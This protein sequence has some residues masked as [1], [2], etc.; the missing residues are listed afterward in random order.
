MRF[1]NLKNFHKN[2]FKEVDDLPVTITRFGIPAYV[3]TKVDTNVVTSVEKV[4][5][6]KALEK[7]LEDIPRCSVPG[8][9][10]PGDCNGK[11][12]D[13]LYGWLDAPMCREHSLKSL[14][15]FSK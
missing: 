15:E 5:T 3:L 10:L 13:E 11:V 2:F 7:D 9:K 14:R 4:Y 1:T 12:W 8:C 6:E